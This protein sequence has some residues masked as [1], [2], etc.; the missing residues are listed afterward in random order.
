MDRIFINDLIAFA[1]IGVYDWEQ[2]I[3]QKVVFN[4][5]MAWDTR[6]AAETDDVKFCLNYA[7]VSQAIIHYTESKP[8]LLIERLANEIAEM[9]QQEFGI[10]W[11]KLTLSKPGAVAQAKSVGIIIERSIE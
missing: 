11:L 1:Q 6:Q 3:K 7:T 9:L 5:E 8:F 10:K 2:Q 4:L